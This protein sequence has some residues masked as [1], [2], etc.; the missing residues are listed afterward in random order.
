MRH[1]PHSALD[2]YTSTSYHRTAC[3]FK[4]TLTSPALPSQPSSTWLIHSAPSC[5]GSATRHE[6]ADVLGE[7]DLDLLQLHPISAA[8]RSSHSSLCALFLHA[9]L[10]LHAKLQRVIR[11]STRYC[12]QIPRP[13][14]CK[15]GGLRS[16]VDTLRLADQQVRRCGTATSS[17]FFSSRL[18]GCSPG[19]SSVATSVIE[20]GTVIEAV[21]V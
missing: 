13:Q 4:H 20:S 7:L 12:Y 19:H 6:Q 10:A 18:P 14:L 21:A 8:R 1:R 2:A 15:C 17:Q 5:S 3:N 11:Q 9:V 16:A